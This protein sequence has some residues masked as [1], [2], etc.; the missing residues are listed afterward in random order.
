MLEFF[1]A[2]ALIPELLLG[3]ANRPKTT[4]AII[5]IFIIILISI[6]LVDFQ[7]TEK[8]NLQSQVETEIEIELEPET[9][10]QKHKI[11][12]FVKKILYE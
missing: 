7:K 2:L 1:Q 8:S 3:L 12:N 11:I 10:P 9:K 4:L 6:V 5:G